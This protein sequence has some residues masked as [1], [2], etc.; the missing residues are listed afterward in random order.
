M[1][2]WLYCLPLLAGLGCALS[3]DNSSRPTAPSDN[4][5]SDGPTPTRTATGPP[6][7]RTKRPLDTAGLEKLARTDPVAFINACVDRYDREVRGYRVTLTK[8]ERVLFKGKVSPLYPPADRPAEV[9]RCAFREKPFSVLM[10]WKQ[11]ARQAQTTLYVKG[12]NE[13]RLL[14]RPASW[15]A[16]LV[17]VT[18]R[19]PNSDDALRTSRYPI[20]EFGIQ[21]GMRRTQEAWQRAQK[22]GDLRV[23]FRGEKRLPELND[24]PC[25]E[26]KRVGYPKPEDDGIVES[27]LYFDPQ[28]WLQIGS[29]LVGE[30]GELIASYFFTDLELNPDFPADTFTRAALTK[31]TKKK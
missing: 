31:K 16:L 15:R 29:I 18:S 17:S 22:R 11:G 26:V 28:N 25:W 24:Q 4:A 2:R 23:L 5:T 6:V 12:E 27:T 10:D 30:K 7:D 19:D 9:V 8:R 3:P 20:T 21:V 14:V 13:D 1:R